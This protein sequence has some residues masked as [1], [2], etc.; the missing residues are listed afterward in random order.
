MYDY[1]CVYLD[2]GGRPIIG[3]LFFPILTNYSQK[4]TFLMAVKVYCMKS[5]AVVC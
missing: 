5:A 1:E 2:N 4:I 3:Q